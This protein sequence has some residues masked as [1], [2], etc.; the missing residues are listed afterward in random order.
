MASAS[1]STTL[2]SSGNHSYTL[3]AYF[4]E[5]STSTPNN[6]SRI[7]VEAKLTSTGYRWTSS[8]NSYLR[9]YWHDNR[10]NYDRLVGEVAATSISNNGSIIA[11]GYIDPLY[12]NSDGNLSGYAYATWTKGGTSNYTP[13]NGSVT[14]SWTALTSIPRQANLTSADNFNDEQ[15]PSISY[16]NPAGNSVSE[17]VAGIYDNAGSV[18]FAG[19]RNVNKTGSSYTF[20]LT[21]TERNNIRN[22]IPNSNSRTVRFYLRTSIGGNYYYSY[23]ERTVTI[24]N[25]N[26]TFNDFTYKDTNS[27]V[28]T[29]T[30]NNQ[31]LVKGLSNLQVTINSSN[32]MVANKK[33]TA[34]NYV[35]TVDTINKSANYSDEDLDV[36][37]GNITSSGSKRLN[38]R[39]YDSRNNSTLVYKDV[40]VY[41][42]DKPII[43]ATITR[44]NNFENETTLKVSGSY[45]KL[46]I[47]DT[48]K[49]I[50][51]KLQY[52]YRETGG[53]WSTWT[54]LTSEIADGKFTCNDVILSLDNTK[55]F[56]FEIQALDKL[57]TATLSLKLDVGQAV[58]FISSN[59]KACYING[60]EILT[61]DVID[62][63]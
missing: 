37:L 38:V 36:G 12:H 46:T 33:A 29:I 31:V 18:C 59:K 45:S 55:S 35:V 32:K 17:L 52:R 20:N 63:W 26:P 3:Q 28:T 27:N 10:E 60:Q 41:D 16:N 54:I 62:T 21:E 24:I 7:Y 9:I 11:S 61:Y 15:N 47:N 42:Y 2:K 39:A 43:N 4:N 44:L 58:F 25:G 48:D 22:S 50:I 30:G 49:N 8:Y 13:N 40:T 1:N 5:E 51:T 6:S 57:E 34:K 23:I 53:A 56:E 14:T 19:Y